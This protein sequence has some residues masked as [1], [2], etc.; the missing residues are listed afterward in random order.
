[1]TALWQLPQ[2]C[3]LGF[4]LL[5]VRA[6][7]VAVALHAA[8]S[9]LEDGLRARVALRSGRTSRLLPMMFPLNEVIIDSLDSKKVSHTPA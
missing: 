8:R 6:P 7:T 5:R 1:M 2:Q 4:R 9:S 3:R